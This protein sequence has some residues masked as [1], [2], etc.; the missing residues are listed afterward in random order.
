MN[1]EVQRIYGDNKKTPKKILFLSQMINR[2]RI[3][4]NMIEKEWN[5]QWYLIYMYW[6]KSMVSKSKKWK[7]AFYLMHSFILII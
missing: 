6:F 2:E 5:D 7:F 4:R 3:V 1:D